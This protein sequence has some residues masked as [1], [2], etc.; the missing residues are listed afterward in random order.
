MYCSNC[1][2][3]VA[4]NAVFCSNCGSNLSPVGASSSH[5]RNTGL[6]TEGDSK[7]KFIQFGVA[8][9]VL[10]IIVALVLLFTNVGSSDPADLI[11]GT[12]VYSNVKNIDG[13]LFPLD[14][15]YVF[16][17]DGKIQFQ[18]LLKEY[19]EGDE[20][21]A[22][23][24]TY[25]VAGNT[26]VIRL[27]G[28]DLQYDLKIEKNKMQ[29]LS[30]DGVDII[31]GESA[32]TLS[33]TSSSNTRSSRSSSSSTNNGSA[34][35]LETQ[36][37]PASPTQGGSDSSALSIPTESGSSSTPSSS[38]T[39]PSTTS[40][41]EGARQGGSSVNSDPPSQSDTFSQGGNSYQSNGGSSASSISSVAIPPGKYINER[42]LKDELF[43]VNDDYRTHIIINS[44]GTFFCR[45]SS[46]DMPQGLI[47]TYTVEGNIVTCAIEEIIQL[48]GGYKYGVKEEKMYLYFRFD[49]ENLVWDTQSVPNALSEDN[50]YSYIG[51]FAIANTRDGD[52]FVRETSPTTATP[53]TQAVA[54]TTFTVL[55]IGSFSHGNISVVIQSD[56]DF[57]YPHAGFMYGEYAI[58]GDLVTFSVQD[59]DFSNDYYVLDNDETCVFYFQYDG[60]NL[61]FLEIVT[62]FKPGGYAYELWGASPS[63]EIIDSQRGDVFVLQQY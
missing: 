54:Q 35:P 39:T 25:L 19:G 55:P 33:K 18:M 36:T 26:L 34:L 10:V 62:F 63:I 27:G 17:K 37:A 50:E 40:P 38:S 49:G 8:G 41:S 5:G 6:K 3:E 22:T 11:V 32:I 15:Q 4:D 53:S 14:Y 20:D 7:K 58:E 56:I 23:E 61:L 57:V 13:S 2:T 45:A 1:G 47:G 44:D 21:E 16:S 60:T 30:R 43:D 29:L 9:A 46:D 24:G 31:T 42:M 12:W 51:N 28:F 48:N 59:I 52:V